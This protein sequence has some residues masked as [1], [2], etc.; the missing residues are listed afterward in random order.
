MIFK[1]LNKIMDLNKN[2][3]AILGVDKNVSDE[4]IKKAYK[5]MALKYHPDKNP[6]TEERFKEINEA[7][8]VLTKDRNVYDNKSRFGKNY[9]PYDDFY[10]VSD[11][12]SNFKNRQNN[13]SNFYTNEN[14]WENNF[15]SSFNFTNQKENLDISIQVN[16]DL[17]KIYKNEK[18]PV[19]YKRNIICDSCN[20]T[21]FDLTSD[22][23]ICPSCSG[24]KTTFF[25]CNLC[26]D[27]GRVYTKKCVKCNGEKIINQETTFNINSIFK[28]RNS[29]KQYLP[30]YGHFSKKY[31]GKVG[32]LTVII[33]Y[34]P[35]FKYSLDND[36]YLIY[37]L[38]LHYE[39]AIKGISYIHDHLDDKKIKI[40]IPEKTKDG[41]LLKVKEKGLIIDNNANMNKRQDLIIKINIVINYDR[42]SLKKEKQ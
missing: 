42:L 27:L 21:G 7:Y 38:D 32:N 30:G 36:K 13:Y 12:F 17:K 24:K 29:E 22:Y 6:N 37:N 18:I 40:K 1:N 41:D 15:G 26:N 23:N 25:K 33:N 11:I 39:D 34:I 10:D 5:K 19:S 28:L 31:L 2:Y 14:I 3:Y 8:Q 16:V 9:N 35:D 4:D 20:G